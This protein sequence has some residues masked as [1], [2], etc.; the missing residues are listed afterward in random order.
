MLLTS[1][2]H[3]LHSL[4]VFQTGWAVSFIISRALM[5]AYDK[6]SHLSLSGH[7]LAEV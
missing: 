3:V 7:G 1:L 6:H 4:D 5:N 2:S